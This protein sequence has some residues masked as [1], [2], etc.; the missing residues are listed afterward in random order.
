MPKNIKFFLITLLI[1]LPLW[2][3]ANNFHGNLEKFFYAQISEPVGQI[4]EIKLPQK[5]PLELK[6]KSAISIKIGRSLK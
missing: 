1:S 5:P 2:W 4:I 3:S 6:A